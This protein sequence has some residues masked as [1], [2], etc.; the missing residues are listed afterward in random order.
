MIGSFNSPLHPFR[1]F[2]WALQHS[3]N[4]FFNN[5]C[6][7]L[8]LVCG[9]LLK[10]VFCGRGEMNFHRLKRREYGGLCQ[11]KQRPKTRLYAEEGPSAEA[12]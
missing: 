3:G 8:T 4:G 11:G 7:L 10:L 5:L 2:L 12:T 1:K 6:R 9:E